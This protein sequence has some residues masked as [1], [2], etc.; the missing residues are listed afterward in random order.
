VIQP[1]DKKPLNA[2]V[3]LLL[4]AVVTADE[5]ANEL[6]EANVVELEKSYRRGDPIPPM[7][8][9]RLDDTRYQLVFGHHRLV[10][11]RRAGLEE[12]HFILLHAKP[13]ELE[14]IELQF[15][16][17]HHR[18]TFT[19]IEMAVLFTRAMAAGGWTGKQVA[20]HFG[21]SESTVSRSLQVNS[22]LVD[23]LKALVASLALNPRMAYSLSRLE[24]AD[25]VPFHDAYKGLPID[26][27]E[28]KIADHLDARGKPAKKPPVLVELPGIRATLQHDAA[29]L[30]QATKQL[31]QACKTL[32][33]RGLPVSDL[34]SLLR[35]QGN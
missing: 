35:I 8:V 33:E 29:A 10:A 28:A 27:F 20:R 24:P 16:E 15:R 13:S 32:V 12:L 7:T 9:Y 5:P 21:V 23:P 31:W 25:Q 14:L 34:P 3:P 26:Q 1:P 11:A 6:D 30:L 18:K 17:N 4:A 22:R 2:I 19:I